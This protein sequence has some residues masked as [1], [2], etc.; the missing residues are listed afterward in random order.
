MAPRKRVTGFPGIDERRALMEQL[1]EIHKAVDTYK[2]L[3]DPD[4]VEEQQQKKDVKTR[5]EA[6]QKRQAQ[7][8]DQTQPQ[9]IVGGGAG[10]MT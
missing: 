5:L 7:A 10:N 8:Q 4:A 3:D 2:R 1:K 6:Q 9:L